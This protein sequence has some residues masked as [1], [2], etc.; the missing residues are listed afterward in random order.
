MISPTSAATRYTNY[1]NRLNAAPISP[2]TAQDGLSYFGFTSK[3]ELRKAVDAYFESRND[4]RARE[5]YFESK[6]DASKNYTIYDHEF[7]ELAASLAKVATEKLA[8]KFL[9]VLGKVSSGS[10]MPKDDWYSSA[11][12]SMTRDDYV[13]KLFSDIKPDCGPGAV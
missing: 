12:K 9:L 1:A 13:D 4:V 5:H 3:D 2:T 11:D 7:S 8:S 6:K 10:F